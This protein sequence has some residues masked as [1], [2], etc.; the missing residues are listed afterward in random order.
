MD[1]PQVTVQDVRELL[2][3]PAEHPV[4]YVKEGPDN[5]GGEFELD[6]WAGALVPHGSIVT[7]RE[8]AA[9]WLGRRPSQDDIVQYP[10]E[11]QED[12]DA[13]VARLTDG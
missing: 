8:A 7:D 6:V 4:L 2:N 10:P 3:S 12:V 5:E 13:A 11:L 9:R 1:G